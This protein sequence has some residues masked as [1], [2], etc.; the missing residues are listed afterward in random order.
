M[1]SYCCPVLCV[2]SVLSVYDVRALWPNSWTDQDETWHAGRP[3]G[4]IVLDG[5]P[6]PP[7]GAQSPIFGRYLLRP[8][9]CMDHDATW[10]GGR[11][12]PRW[13]CV[14]FG[15]SPLSKKGAEPPP[16]KFSADV[17]CGQ[18]AGWIKITLGMEVGLCPGDFLLGGNPAP[19]RK[20]A[21]A[22]LLNFRPIFI[23]V[24]RLDASRCH[25]V[26]R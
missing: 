8:N 25:L 5:D 17:Y 16:S 6:A 18:T 10:Y 19:L 9:G 22:S 24:K 14:R 11:P 20:K 7:K 15:P 21:A 13:L 2:L 3:A 12:W 23:V 26:C 4:H 1:L